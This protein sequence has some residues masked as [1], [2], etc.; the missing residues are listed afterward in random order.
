MPPMLPENTACPPHLVSGTLRA[1]QHRLFAVAVS[2]SVLRFCPSRSTTAASHK[3]WHQDGG[4]LNIM[5]FKSRAAEGQVHLFLTVW[6]RRCRRRRRTTG[7]QLRSN[8]LTRLTVSTVC[9]APDWSGT[10]GTETSPSNCEA[11]IALFVGFRYVLWFS[12]FTPCRTLLASVGNPGTCSRSYML[13]D[14]STYL[15]PQWLLNPVNSME[16]PMLPPCSGAA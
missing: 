15:S 2:S 8:P 10:S 3:R 4:R 16:N 14:P 5:R 12:S 11:S 13:L 9:S 1:T 6:R 7:R